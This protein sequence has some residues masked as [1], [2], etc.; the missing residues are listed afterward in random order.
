MII[1]ISDMILYGNFVSG[2]VMIL[3]LMLIVVKNVII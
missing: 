3:K 1:S 2:N